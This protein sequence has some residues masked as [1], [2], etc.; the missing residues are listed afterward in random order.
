MEDSSEKMSAAM[1]QAIVEWGGNPLS[2]PVKRD[3]YNRPYADLDSI[4]EAISKKWMGKLFQ[5]IERNVKSANK[6]IAHTKKRLNLPDARGV[7]LVANASNPY[8]NNPKAY[9]EALGALVCK[10]T[11]T[12]ERRYAQID[13]GVYFSNRLLSQT[14]KMPFWAPFHIEEPDN[15]NTEIQA[16]ML[17]LRTQW[18][19]Y[20]EK[21]TGVTVRQHDTD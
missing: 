7:I 18:Y 5:E 10:R 3:E 9:R 21:T 20:I 17:E 14:E 1:L 13:G 12:G 2:I 15:T 19:V 4:P 8:H 16:F 11:N 6:Q